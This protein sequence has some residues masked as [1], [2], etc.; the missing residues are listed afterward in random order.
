M[1]ANAKLYN[2]EG[3]WVWLDAVELQKVFDE[4]YEKFCANT[5]LPGHSDPAPTSLT[6]FSAAPEQ[7]LQGGDGQ[8]NVKMNGSE[9]VEESSMNPASFV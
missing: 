4:A 2:Q 6:G 7:Q 8:G 5:D 9:F 1:F 3:S